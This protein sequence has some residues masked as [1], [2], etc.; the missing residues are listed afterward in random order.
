MEEVKV[1]SNERFDAYL[2]SKKGDRVFAVDRGRCKG[3]RICAHIC[4][5]DALDMSSNKS[6]RGYFFPLENGKCTAC[7]QCVYACPDF[8]LSVHKLSEVSSEGSS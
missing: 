5:Y 8:A 6:M 1:Q 7:R 3:C 4:P 2:V